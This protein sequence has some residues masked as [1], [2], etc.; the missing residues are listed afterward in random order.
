MNRKIKIGD[1]VI[2]DDSMPFLIAEAGVNYYDIASKMSIEPLE[3]AKLMISEAKRGGASAIKFQTY[4]AEKLASKNSPAYWDLSKEHT[5]SQYELFKK[6]DRFG[7]DE[8]RELSNYAKNIGIIFLSTPFDMESVDYLDPL[9]PAFKVASSD[10]TNKPFLEYIAEKGKPVILSTGASTIEEIRDAVNWMKNAGDIDIAILHCVL[11]YPTK[12]EDANLGMI[13]S[14]SEAFPDHIIGY[15]D[16]TLPSEDMHIL[17]TAYILGAR[18][19]EKHF[20]L[21][22]TIPG[23]D[24]FHSMDVDDMLNFMKLAKR[25]KKIVGE[26]KKDIVPCEKTSRLYARRS[27]VASQDIDAGEIIERDMVTFKR[28]GTGI[29]PCELEKLVGKKSKNKISE[30]EI[31]TWDMIR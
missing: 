31:I 10:I 17:L 8:Y 28:P 25:A 19:I 16:H 7:E 5:T 30:D 18:V 23:N 6:Y 14:L 26:S 4:K 13:P 29:C 2:S 15:S 22:K 9:V 20:T 1:F 12:D 27:I 24:H 21:D 3:A 11:C